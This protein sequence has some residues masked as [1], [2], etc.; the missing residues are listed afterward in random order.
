MVRK[1]YS[2]KTGCRGNTGVSFFWFIHFEWLSRLQQILYIDKLKS[3]IVER[4]KLG[5][6]SLLSAILKTEISVWDLFVLSFEFKT[7]WTS[8]HFYLCKFCSVL[9]LNKFML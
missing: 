4:K 5:F 3:E 8:G 6:A 9:L 2:A 1:L 7:A